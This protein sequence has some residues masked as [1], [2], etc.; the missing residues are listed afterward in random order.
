MRM[1]PYIG[2][3]NRSHPFNL[4]VDSVSVSVQKTPPPAAGQNGAR[5]R[6]PA[7]GPDP[8]CFHTYEAS[9]TYSRRWSF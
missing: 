2:H 8:A 4:F 1:A 6:M 9:R 7:D 5:L 3:D